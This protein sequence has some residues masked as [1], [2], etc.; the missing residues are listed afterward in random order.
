L[1]RRKSRVA[2]GKGKG[3]WRRGFLYREEARKRGT[4]GKEMEEEVHK[5]STHKEITR[6]EMGG[7]EERMGRQNSFIKCDFSR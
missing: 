3:L 1:S 5:T 7:E 4:A 6:K 2:K